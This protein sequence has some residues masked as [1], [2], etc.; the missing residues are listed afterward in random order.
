M[1]GKLGK[2]LDFFSSG[3]DVL[4]YTW[5]DFLFLMVL[6]FLVLLALLIYYLNPKAEETEKGDIV[7]P[8]NVIVGIVWPDSKN[9]DV[10]LWVR[11]PGDVPVGWSNLNGVIFNLLRDDLGE[12]GDAAGINYENAFSRGI[13]PGEYV[14]NVQWFADY[15]GSSKMP[16]TVVVSVKKSLTAS[17]GA[18]EAQITQILKTDI[19]LRYVGEE[20]TATRFELTDDGKLV[21]G[22][23]NALFKP[24][25]TKE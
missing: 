2:D 5:R 20:I 14:I 24:L 9:S 13:V 22:S 17:D 18:S 19:E 12:A 4:G 23:I 25:V 10:D 8:G 7:P 21:P 1:F 15:S 6:T 3:E 16:V 11:A